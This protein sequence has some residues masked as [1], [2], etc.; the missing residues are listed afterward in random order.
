MSKSTS[1][2]KVTPILPG[3]QPAIHTPEPKTPPPK[4]PAAQTSPEEANALRNSMENNSKRIK[5]L[6][7]LDILLRR[8]TT[9]ITE[10]EELVATLVAKAD[11]S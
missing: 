3:G 2:Y 10:A 8:N 11:V 6:Q 4:S 1:G 7:S 5:L 9:L